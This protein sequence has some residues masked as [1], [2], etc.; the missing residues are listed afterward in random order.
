MDTY[1]SNTD[2]VTYLLAGLA[3]CPAP[4]GS[5]ANSASLFS[6]TG[7]SVSVSCY[8]CQGRNHGWRVEGDQGLGSNTG[9]L[10]PRARPKAEL[11][12]G[13]RRG[14]PPPAV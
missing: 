7:L 5:P 1:H 9:A 14:S 11:G 6:Y 10:G 4:I 12:V 13:C 2:D 8:S 3:Y